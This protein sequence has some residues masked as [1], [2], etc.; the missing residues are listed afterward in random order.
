MTTP[1]R[2][3]LRWC[4]PWTLVW[5]ATLYGM[6]WVSRH[7]ESWCWFPNTLLALLVWLL[8]TLAMLASWSCWWDALREAD[9]EASAPRG[10]TPGTASPGLA[11]PLSEPHTPS[12][13][14]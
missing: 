7:S 1:L 5:V 14:G 9:K 12:D 11:S 6:C 13:R 8:V 10:G 3:L 4:L 2:W